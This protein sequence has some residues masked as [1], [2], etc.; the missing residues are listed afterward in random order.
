MTSD[1]FNVWL[2]DLNSKC[3]KE[4]RKILLP[5]DNCPAHKIQKKF[6]N[7]EIEFFPKNATGVIQ[8]LDMGSLKP[9]YEV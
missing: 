2:S 5:M 1:L 7:I 9:F 6:T 3:I 8:P 4:N